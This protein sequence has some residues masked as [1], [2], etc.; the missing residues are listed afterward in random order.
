MPTTLCAYPL[1][2]KRKHAGTRGN[3]RLQFLRG[4]ASWAVLTLCESVALEALD[5]VIHS[6]EQKFPHGAQNRAAFCVRELR[7]FLTQFEF[8]LLLGSEWT[9]IETISIG[10]PSR[11]NLIIQENSMGVLR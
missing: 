11:A 6:L 5:V 4:S 8:D 9:N 2:S 10:Q 1:A 3:T 7:Q